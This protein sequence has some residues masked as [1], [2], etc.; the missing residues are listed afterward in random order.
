MD[1]LYHK[2]K[3]KCFSNLIL[4][5]LAGEPEESEEENVVDEDEDL[6]SEEEEMQTDQDK[7]EH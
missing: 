2:T 4:R 5:E 7:M 3:F 6:D 1:T